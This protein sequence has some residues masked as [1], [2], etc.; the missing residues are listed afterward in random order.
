M[1]DL[2]SI[3]VNSILQAAKTISNRFTQG[4]T[5]KKIPVRERETMMPVLTYRLAALLLTN[6]EESLLCEIAARSVR[7]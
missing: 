4:M 3:W 2:T 6:V 7:R 5:H 1:Q